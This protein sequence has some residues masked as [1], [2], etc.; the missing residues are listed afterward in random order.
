[1]NGDVSWRSEGEE[2]YAATLGYRVVSASDGRTELLWQPGPPWVNR[3]G[4]VFGGIVAAVVDSVAGLAL[5][6]SFETPPRGAT[7]TMH[8]DYLRPMAIG[9]TYTCRG[10]ALRVGRRIA[11]G[12]A[13]IY[14][15]E[16]GLVVRGTVTMSIVPPP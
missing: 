13:W 16:G 8:V 5:A 15:P 1:V 4:G 6:S 7:V 10:E 3:G 9:V 12:D 11:V 14:D 2:E